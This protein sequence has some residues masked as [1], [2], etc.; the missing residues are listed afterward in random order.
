[1][2]LRMLTLLVALVLVL[3]LIVPSVGAQ[4]GITY[5]SGFQVQN[6]GTGT[7]TISISFY[8][9]DGSVAANHSDT[10]A[11]NTNKTYFPI[12]GVSDG[13]NGSAV[14]SSDQPVAAITNLLGNYPQYGGSTTGFTAG[15][16]NV[17]LPLIMRGNSGFDTWFNVQNTGNAPANITI[18]Y[19]PAG[20]GSAHSETATIPVGAAK[21]FNQA[22]TTQLGTKFVGSA[23]IVSQDQPVAAMVNQV[24]TGSI[25]ALLMYDGFTS[26]SGSTTVLTPLIM[27]N[28][29]GFFTGISVQNVGN[30]A[31]S[32]T[33]DYGPNNNGTLDPTDDTVSLA[34]GGSA[35]VLQSGGQWGSNRYV[36]SARITA[37]QPLVVVVNQLRIAGVSF[38]TAYEGF[39]SANLTMKASAPLIMANN[40]GFFT[41]I[42]CQNAGTAATNVTIDY[43]PNTNGSFQP[44]D[45]SFSV[46]PGANLI[47]LQNGGAWGNNRY[48]GS[49]TVTSSASN[50][51]CIVNELN[52]SAAGDQFLTYNAINY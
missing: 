26:S 17:G 13:F 48:V 6:L 50:I 43:A 23:T 44:A 7:A 30:A 41:S 34:V 31:T 46:Q 27:A 3:I 29:S 47:T 33:I 21:T 42:Q 24:G 25:K 51:A 40:S 19:T 49:A 35:N 12:P 4:Q 32:A 16:T 11:A 39:S 22:S 10:I 2:K 45:E 15:A 14:I 20:S 5:S 52:L 9:Q 28:N 37:S 18:T 36:G 38:G 1:M 8:N